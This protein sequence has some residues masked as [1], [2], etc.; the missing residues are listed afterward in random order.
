MVYFTPVPRFAN[1]TSSEIVI[2]SPSESVAGAGSSSVAE[3][4]PVFAVV[5]IIFEL[6]YLLV[7]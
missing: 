1:S 3:E 5:F 4:S 2:L 6:S 7:N